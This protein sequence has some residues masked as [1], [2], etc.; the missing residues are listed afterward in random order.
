M[1]AKVTEKLIKHLS[2]QNYAIIDQLEVEFSKGFNIITGETGAGKSILLGAIGLILGNRAET[3]TLKNVDKKCIVEG[4][5]S[6]SK[7]V[8]LNN[9]MATLD[10]DNEAEIIIRREIAPNG[11]TRAFVND[12]PVNLAQLKQI[13][14]TLVDL[15]QQFDT[16]ELGE[17]DFQRQVLDAISQQQHEVDEF[18]NQYQAYNKLQKELAQLKLAH[19]KANATSDYNKYLFQELEEANFQTSELENLNEELKLLQN[20]EAIK[21]NLEQATQAL[22]S[23][24]ST[25]TLQIKQIIQILKSVANYHKDIVPLVER[26]QSSVVELTDINDEL[27]T[28]NEHVTLDAERIEIVND[29]IN[30]G[31]KL[32]K[33]HNVQSTN[34]LIKI[35]ADLEIQIQGLFNTD[36]DI[37]LKT[38]AISKLES[39]LKKLADSLH[40]KRSQAAPILSQK[41]TERLHQVG[42]PNAQLKI[43]VESTELNQFGN[44]QIAFLFDA[45]KSGKFEPIA[46]VASGGE[47]SRLMLCV[48]SLVAGAI[49]LP[50]LIFDEIDTGISG[51]AAKQV[52]VIMAELANQHQILSITHQPQIAAMADRHYF[53]YKTQVNNTVSTGIKILE[54][55]ERI[56]TIA[57][58]LSGEKPTEAALKIAEEMCAFNNN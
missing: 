9:V 8:S 14:S 18:K 20:G 54:K 26:L 33:K 48:K 40:Q 51:E 50:V 19:D 23:G 55:A 46:K 22:H 29:R 6:T 30:L 32:Q 42:M 41:I 52:G 25:A 5:F 24:E 12:T 13:S 11:K 47:L 31:Y 2:I 37:K 44:S 53:V 27:E 17:A 3:N 39:E 57:Q 35:K 36:D 43:N 45:N 10:I 49:H 38:T 1:H 4:V 56:T 7:N 21:S 16:L 15:H 28:L 58:M 34:E